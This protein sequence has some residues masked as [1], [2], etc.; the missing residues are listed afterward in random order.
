MIDERSWKNKNRDRDQVSVDEKRRLENLERERFEDLDEDFNDD[1][2]S[3]L[4]SANSM[5]TKLVNL[6]VIFSFSI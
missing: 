4:K 6:H 3:D 1:L 2:E 5:N